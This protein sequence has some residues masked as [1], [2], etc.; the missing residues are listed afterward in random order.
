[1]SIQRKP[2]RTSR[3]P[4]SRCRRLIS[5]LWITEVV[6]NCASDS[7]SVMMLSTVRLATPLGNW[8]LP[9][10]RETDQPSTAK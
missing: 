1:M 8:P 6:S 3:L 7:G 10:D 5:L 9:K 2:V 4:N